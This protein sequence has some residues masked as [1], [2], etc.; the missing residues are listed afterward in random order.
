MNRI[1]PL[2]IVEGPKISKVPFSR[3]IYIDSPDKVLIDSGAEP[4][5][6]FDLQKECGIELIIN[7]HYHPDHTQQ[8]Y[9]FPDVT[10]AIN[11]I[12]FKTVR[13]IEGVAKANGIFQ[14]WGDAG[15]MD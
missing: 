3:S 5:T 9:L 2:V 4:E 8:N 11:P 7:T 13:T 6:L 12:E 14:E 15:G 1:G 10:K